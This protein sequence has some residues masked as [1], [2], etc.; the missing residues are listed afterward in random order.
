MNNEH[1]V[2]TIISKLVLLCEVFEFYDLG[3][4]YSAEP[5][6]IFIARYIIF[7]IDRH[8]SAIILYPQR[9]LYFLYIFDQVWVAE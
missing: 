6:L 5:H 7:L 2:V 1:I 9:F 3:D 8:I 4:I